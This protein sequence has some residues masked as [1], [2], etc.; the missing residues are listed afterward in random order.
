M[1]T[2][3]KDYLPDTSALVDDANVIYKLSKNNNITI[4]TMVVRELKKI[5]S[6]YRNKGPEQR[7][8]ARTALRIINEFSRMYNGTPVPIPETGG[9]IDFVSPDKEY[10]HADP[11]LLDY[12]KEQKSKGNGNIIL[13]SEDT[14]LNI[15]ARISGYK[16][17]EISD[18]RKG[19]SIEEILDLPDE[20]ILP[21]GARKS[22]IDNKIKEYSSEELLKLNGEEVIEKLI[23]NQYLHLSGDTLA[24]R[25]LGNGNHHVFENVWVSDTKL[26]QGIMP[27]NKEQKYL[28]H[29]CLEDNIEC[30]SF[31]GKA[32]TGKSLVTLACGLEQVLETKRY[33][34]LIIVRPLT[35][36]GEGIGFLPGD[37]GA[38]I[39]PFYAAIRDNMEVISKR[40][41]RIK[42]S[43]KKKSRDDDL[44]V[45]TM[46]L[47]YFLEEG[48]IQFVPPTFL[49]GR[50]IPNAFIV[51]DEAQNFD[52]NEIKTMITRSGEGSKLILNGDPYQID[53]PYLDTE[54]NGLTYATKRLMGADIFSTVILKKGERSRLAELAAD[55][56]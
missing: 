39:D 31:L 22:L 5:R 47:D 14:E 33:N 54:N 16:A 49:R 11:A 29:A 44:N 6:D 34:K 32:G 17:Q 9:T 53:N 13:V 4:H 52:G 48:I 35:H 50:S 18:R 10:S 38:K 41:G 46:D 3:G 45:D 1:D 42:D 56:L 21:H 55:R 23:H 37:M 20:I 40:R 36:I 19:R 8:N 26:V 24:L 43:R 27:R 2:D 25:Y 30:A 28:M 51:V 12:L 15:L 7:G